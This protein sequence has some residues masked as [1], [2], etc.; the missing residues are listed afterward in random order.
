MAGAFDRV[1]SELLMG[2]LESFGL[3]EKLLKVIR[4]WLRQRLGFV[5]VS[6][7]QIIADASVEYGLSGDGLGAPALECI[8]WRL[9]LRD[10]LLWV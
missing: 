4:S 1:D 9:H 8:L 5:I 10:F 6:C 2:K 7:R 3:N